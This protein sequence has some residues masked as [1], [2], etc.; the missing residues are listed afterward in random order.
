MLN[1]AILSSFG[2][3][4][5]FHVFDFLKCGSNKFMALTDYFVPKIFSTMEK[6]QLRDF[7]I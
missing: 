6:R 2:V 5:C 1:N 3:I 4:L 7:S